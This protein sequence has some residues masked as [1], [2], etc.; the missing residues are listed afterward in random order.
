M[1]QPVLTIAQFD[2]RGRI[3]EERLYYDMIAARGGALVQMR[4]RNPADLLP[5]EAQWIF[6]DETFDEASNTK[7]VETLF[8]SL[9]S[10]HVEHA[11]R[12]LADNATY[13]DQSFGVQ[14]SVHQRFAQNYR[15]SCTER[16]TQRLL[17][18]GSGPLA[19]A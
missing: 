7:I 16:P 1:A 15:A 5:L 6:A 11:A 9:R 2:A 8:S 13:V 19:I 17:S 18:L 10:G 12:A 3:Y 14:T 4:P